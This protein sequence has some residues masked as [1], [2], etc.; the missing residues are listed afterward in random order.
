MVRKDAIDATALMLYRKRAAEPLL[1]PLL[2][3][4][5]PADASDEV[6]CFY[7][8]TRTGHHLQGVTNY[9]RQCEGVWCYLAANQ[10]APPGAEDQ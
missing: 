7:M 5:P 9:C 6:L 2:I 8:R 1:P 4:A 3:A 10:G